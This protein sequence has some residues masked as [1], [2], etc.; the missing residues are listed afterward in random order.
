MIFAEP[1][2]RPSLSFPHIRAAAAAQPQLLI[3][4]PRYPATTLSTGGL[5]SPNAPPPLMSPTDAA[6]SALLYPGTYLN[7]DPAYAGTAT[8]QSTALIDIA[9]LQVDGM[10]PYVH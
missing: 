6:A 10:S 1:F 2:L 9:Q 3:S 7:I 8:P 5:V 4:P